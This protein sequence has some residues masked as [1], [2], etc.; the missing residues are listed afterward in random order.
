MRIA[1]LAPNLYSG[2][3]VP[4]VARFLYDTVLRSGGQ[5]TLFSLATAARD[6]LSRRLVAPKSWFTQPSL[7]PNRWNDV[8]IIEAG[9]PLAEL[10]FCRY[11]PSRCLTEKLAE[12]D[13]VQVVSGYPAW[14]GVARNVK[15]P[16][17]LQVAT[18]AAVE[19]KGQHARDHSILAPWRRGMTQITA[20]LDRRYVRLADR[21]FVENDWMRQ[22]A[23]R[24][25]GRKRVVFAPP[26]VDCDR[27]WPQ[28]TRTRRYLLCFGRLGD[29]RKNHGLLLRAYARIVALLPDAPP[30]V[31]AG[32]GKFPD[33]LKQLQAELGLRNRVEIRENVPEEELPALY[34]GAAVFL[35]SSDEEG[36]G[37]VL[38]EAMACGTP[39]VS[40]DCGGPAE[41]VVPGTGHL[42]PIGDAEMLAAKTVDLLSDA[43]GLAAAGA[44]ARRRMEEHFSLEQTGERFIK[45]YR[46]LV[47][48]GKTFDRS[49]PLYVPAKG[50]L[51][52]ERGAGLGPPAN[53]FAQDGK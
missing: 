32:R 12:F 9:A 29:E 49:M 3:G 24:E 48:G 26:G 14:A 23:E 5:A 37:L 25:C 17:C 41:I 50:P 21:V 28:P 19:R 36:L 35:L 47:S 46:E 38:L 40:T 22:W 13:L 34:A 7:R 15:R 11:R 16:L 6:R 2:G 33:A 30:L 43:D 20:R 44:A 53:Y 8:D 52:A 31:I 10:E 1:I 18:L 27:F 51:C 4:R 45:A 42:V 39:V